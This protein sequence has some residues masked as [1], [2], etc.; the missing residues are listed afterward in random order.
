MKRR[1]NLFVLGVLIL[2][3]AVPLLQAQMN[4][5]QPPSALVAM[6]QV[7]PGKHLEFLKWQAAN[8]AINKEAGLPAT[9]WYAHTDGASWDYLAI[10][11]VLTDE[12]QNK[13]DEISKKKG[14]LTGF[15]ASLQFREFVSSHTDTFVVGPV[16]A[17]DLVEAGQ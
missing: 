8:E 1:F 10:G 2:A 4:T 16:S 13:V 7:A 6:Y 15:K 12:Q 9:Q 3:I 17:A 11:P 14:R 5:N